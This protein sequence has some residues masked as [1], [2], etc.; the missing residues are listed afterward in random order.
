MFSTSQ[1]SQDHQTAIWCLNN[2]N[3]WITTDASNKLY[4]WDV[5]EQKPS[6]IFQSSRI[7]SPIIEVTEVLHLKLMATA[8]LDK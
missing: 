8:S 6:F 7:K 5:Q 1:Y 3:F 4:K 2:Y